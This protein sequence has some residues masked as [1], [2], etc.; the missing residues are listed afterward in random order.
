MKHIIENWVWKCI[1]KFK[2]KI[3]YT[4]EWQYQRIVYELKT[5]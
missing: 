1:C 2:I 4:K 3:H 5:L